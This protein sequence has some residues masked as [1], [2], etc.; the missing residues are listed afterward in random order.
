MALCASCSSLTVTCPY[1]YVPQSDLSLP[2]LFLDVFCN[3]SSLVLKLLW[4]L[5][6]GFV[7]RTKAEVR[8]VLDA[9]DCDPRTDV[10]LKADPDTPV[11]AP[12]VK[13]AAKAGAG[14][15]SFASAA[16]LEK[17]REEFQE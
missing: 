9:T 1:V 4:S 10:F 6:C 8:A 17:E 11:F 13:F 14:L 12:N 16:D 15:V 3:S 5:G 7:C 2:L